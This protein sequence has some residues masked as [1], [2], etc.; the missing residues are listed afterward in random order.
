MCVFIVFIFMRYKPAH[1]L[2]YCVCM[3]LWEELGVF[4][5]GGYSVGDARV[6]L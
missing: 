4:F 3:C 5:G 2:F 6:C 1:L